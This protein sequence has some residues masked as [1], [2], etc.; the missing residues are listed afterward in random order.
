MTNNNKMFDEFPPVSKEKWEEIIQKDLKGADYE[1]K[2]VW[3]T[4]EGFKVH[5]YYRQEDLTDKEYLETL[6]GD[7]PFI[8]GNNKDI[9]EWE[10]RQD[11]EVSDPQVSNKEALFLLDKGV[12]SLGF[13]LKCEKDLCTIKNQD[14]LSKLLKDIHIDCIGLYF[15]S[16]HNTPD[17]LK[18][19]SE[20]VQKRG[21][22]KEKIKGAAC[23][24]PIGFLTVKGKWGIDEDSDFSQVADTI[25]FA[26]KNLPSY[27]V[28]AING[29]HFNNAGATA[30]QELALSLAISAEY[31]TRLTEIEI[32]VTTIA[33]HMQINLGVGTS[34]FIEIAK[35]RAT[36]YLFAKLLEA[37]SSDFKEI[38]IN[39]FTSEW[40]N[41]LYDPYVNVLRG[42]TGAMSAIIGGANTL[43]INPFDKSYK[44][45]NSFSDRIA[46]NIQIILKEE[47][48]FD[49]V[50]DPSSG[51]Y[52]IESLT[53]S[54]IEESWKLFLEIDSQGGYLKAL[55]DGTIQSALDETALR[56]D[57]NVATRR[58]ILLGTNQFPNF[59]ESVNDAIEKDT[60]SKKAVEGIVR[61]IKKYRG[62]E[63][64][65]ALRLAVEKHSNRPKV[66]MLTYGNLAFRKARA[67][68]S[69]NF[70][71]CAGYEVIDNLG[72]NSAIDGVNAAKKAGA[73]MIVVCSHDDEYAEFVPEVK[74]LLKDEAIL[75]VAGAPKCMDELKLKGIEHF[76]HVKSNVLETLK[77]FNTKLGIKG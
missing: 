28:L 67:T 34:Y 39:S 26:S 44:E 58:E 56:R 32:D 70:F 64:F 30:V 33:K 23:Y 69:C 21:F 7:F 43:V 18:L 37:Y 50:V 12:T 16:G 62:G 73:D 52:Y 8:R 46:R 25:K 36:R 40:N 66:F 54:I 63:A 6:P 35:I 49:K 72:F 3:N 59:N 60:S 48:Y 55:K 38:N 14:E 17:I 5:P 61:T 53:D 1:R 75:V 31:L 42:T 29:Q 57:I 71:A 22:D 19:L 2:L 4:P 20:E 9:Y 65:E 47:S 24:D 68:F 76:I 74:E 45:T 27:K 41:T 13:G 51:S 15:K 10:I 77:E 11:I